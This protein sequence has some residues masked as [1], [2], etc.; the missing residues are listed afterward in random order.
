MVIDDPITTLAVA[1]AL[2][3]AAQ[4]LGAAL[5][6]PAIVA[7]LGAGLAVGPGLGLIDPDATFGDLLSPT[8]A[9]GVA[10]LLF[11]GGLSLRWAD[12]GSTTRRVVVRMLTI[13]VV[14]SFVGA[15]IAALALTDLPRGVAV[16]FGAIMVVTGPTVVIP[17][18]R[19][20]RLRPR[21]GGILRW[22]GIIIDPVGAVLG[23]SVLEVLL[24]QDGT[25][26]G[27]VAALVSTTVIGCA[28]GLAA[29]AILVVVLDRHW[30]PDNLRGPLSLVAV[31]GAFALANELSTEAGLYAVTVLGIAVANQRRVP[32]G[33]IAELH[34]HLA[35]VVL[36]GIF[37]V[38]GAGVEAD[39][40]T[41]N[42]VPAALVLV[43][44]VLLVRPA[45]VL[46]STIGTPLTH[47]ERAYLAGLAP[48]G[49]VAASVS[50]VFAA[51]LTAHDL[52]GGEDL[53][54]LT[55]LVVAGTTLVYGP[56]AAPLARRLRVDVP[57]PKGVALVGARP[58]VRTLGATLGDLGVQVLVVAES[59]A[60]ADAAR[61]AG[62]L[63]FAGRLEGDG[64]AEALEGI[65]ARVA[66]VGTG[67]EALEAFGSERILRSLGRANVWRVARDDE[68]HEDLVHGDAYEG[69][70]AFG[71]T[72][73]D[74][75]DDVLAA[76]GEMITLV[77]ATV[78]ADG[79][80]PLVLVSGDGVP[81]VAGERAR[82]ASG[83]RLIVL[84]PAAGTTG[85]ATPRPPSR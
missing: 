5:R 33:P 12:I 77:G 65:G 79:D 80:L 82:P 56:T 11:D 58:W 68:H 44:L 43:V 63:V 40:L 74:R 66:I 71:A 16:L 59:P 13:G 20:A 24:V 85:G 1:V 76:G 31:V 18:L 61:D 37:V 55:F 84:R 78:P 35:S 8:I 6:L 64:L 46:A 9:L 72:T 36:A 41:G 73:Q 15:S 60:A 75:L 53:A 34:E 62:L 22:E 51:E 81:S 57:E 52:P 28:V 32:I 48:R 54:A 17:L 4:W 50:A 30:I 7:M 27:T 45:S 23:V 19:Q 29:A 14:V 3:V 69:R 67:A 2:G 47:R 21:V 26:A 42:L 25:L 49:I 10:M 70:H 83:E 39:D 38:L